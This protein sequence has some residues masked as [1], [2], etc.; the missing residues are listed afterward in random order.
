MVLGMKKISFI[1]TILLCVALF[2]MTGCSNV[3][4]ESESTVI[5]VT[6]MTETVSTEN[7]ET[8][9]SDVIEETSE[10]VTA[11]VTTTINTEEV[12]E[13]ESIEEESVATFGTMEDILRVSSIKA[14][15]ET[16]VNECYVYV[17]S[18]ENPYDIVYDYGDEYDAY[19]DACDW[20]LVFDVE[21]YKENFPMLALL[22]NYDD[23]L[24]LKHFQTVGVHEGRQGSA[25]FNVGA[26]IANGDMYDD[27]ERNF[28]AYYF[29]YMLNYETEKHVNT[30]SSHTG[31]TVYRQYTYV[32]TACQKAEWSAVNNYREEVGS[33][34]IVFESELTALANYRAYVNV[35]EGYYAH[36]WLDVNNNEAIFRGYADTIA[37][38]DSFSEN[39]ITNKHGRVYA[40]STFASRYRNSES[41]YA[42]MIDA[43]YDYIGISNV[44]YDGHHGSQFDLF[45]GGDIHTPM[46]P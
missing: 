28:A 37:E 3:S 8:I 14:A 42:A 10:T 43:D 23:E 41:H 20:S 29:Y 5:P 38:W 21:Y 33:Q 44:Y 31:Y 16:D 7:A 34:D 27:F 35:T 36:D 30:V 15:C 17:T 32:P 18:T 2:C 6:T 40:G 1:L 25:D 26:Y 45:I 22:Y 46:F 13:S 39:N 19:V 11:E 24:L 12:I 4:V 9:V